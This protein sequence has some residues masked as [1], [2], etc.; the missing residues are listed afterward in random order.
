MLTRSESLA[1]LPAVVAIRTHATQSLKE[2]LAV[3]AN[4]PSTYILVSRNPKNLEL[5]GT[6]FMKAIHV[7]EKKKFYKRR[8]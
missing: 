1:A 5:L 8:K 3:M 7:H 4:G 6:Y 2:S